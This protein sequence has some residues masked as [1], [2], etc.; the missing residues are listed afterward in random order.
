MINICLS[1]AKYSFFFYYQT[2]K[3]SVTTENHHMW[4]ASALLFLSYFPKGTKTSFSY[5]NEYRQL[6]LLC[7]AA[8]I[9]WNVEL[10]FLFLSLHSLFLSTSDLLLVLFDNFFILICEFARNDKC[11]LTGILLLRL[12]NMPIETERRR[13]VWE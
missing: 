3:K 1:N 4:L 5:T 6:L 10:W 12:N 11:I 7:C 8:K 2:T 9:K 13:K